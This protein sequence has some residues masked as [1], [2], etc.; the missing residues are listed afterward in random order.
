MRF[1]W[2]TEG[3]RSHVGSWLRAECLFSTLLCALLM[4]VELVVSYRSLVCL[5]SCSQ[6]SKSSRYCKVSHFLLSAAESSQ[7]ET[8]IF[9]VRR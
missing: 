2:F 7:I 4:T 6:L 3:T 1:M 9:A 8:V 5:S